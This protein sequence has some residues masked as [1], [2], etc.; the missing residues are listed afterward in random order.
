ML[1]VLDTVEL[2]AGLVMETC[3]GVVSAAGGLGVMPRE[4]KTAKIK[5][6]VDLGDIIVAIHLRRCRKSILHN[7]STRATVP[8][9][10]LDVK[11]IRD[12][13][14]FFQSEKG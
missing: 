9:K 2:F 7:L 5:I 8:H 10:H 3:G 1:I 11:L 4:K 13:D 12:S 6:R 14:L